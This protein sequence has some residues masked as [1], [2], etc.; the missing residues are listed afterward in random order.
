MQGYRIRSSLCE[1]LGGPIQTGPLFF[2]SGMANGLE[3]DMNDTPQFTFS[4]EEFSGTVRLFP[5][6]NL[7]LFPHVVQPLH[8]FEPRY[9]DL[10]SES[11]EDDKLIGMAT[12]AAGWEDDYDGKPPVS[13]NACL[14][15]VIVHRGLEDGSHNILLAGVSRIE[16]VHELAS[17]KSFRSAEAVLREDRCSEDDAPRVGELLEELRQVMAHL[18]PFVPD[19]RQQLDELLDREIPLGTLTDLIAYLL[20][21]DLADKL[22]L[23]GEDNVV[24]RAEILTKRLASLSSDTRTSGQGELPFPPSPSRN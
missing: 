15:R 16:L 13:P 14:G 8:V 10:L 23:L 3:S 9:C 20:D 18:L 11:L 12:L 17:A 22:I 21:V 5:L 19:A 1:A 7:V 6:P 24:C 4:S 2:H